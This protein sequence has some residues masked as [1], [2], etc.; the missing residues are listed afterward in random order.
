MAAPTAAR[1]PGRPIVS[2][3]TIV[4]RHCSGGMGT[5]SHRERQVRS[6]FALK[7]VFVTSGSIRA[8]RNR[9]KR[10]FCGCPGMLIS[11]LPFASFAMQSITWTKSPSSNL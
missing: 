4:Q 5:P 7:A 6:K 2:A 11:L 8:S 10:T 9:V 1:D 3:F